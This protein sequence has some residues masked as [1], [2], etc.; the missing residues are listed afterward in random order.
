MSYN[1]YLL[2]DPP[3]LHRPSFTNLFSQLVHLLNR[4]VSVQCAN[5]L[6][7]SRVTLIYQVRYYSEH[8]PYSTAASPTSATARAMTPL[9]ADRAAALAIH[10]SYAS[11]SSSSVKSKPP[12][13]AAALVP[14]VAPPVV[15][16]PLPVQ[17]S[18]VAGLLPVQV[19][20]DLTI[21]F[22]VFTGPGNS[23]QTPTG[24]VLA[25][26]PPEVATQAPAVPT[27]LVPV[28]G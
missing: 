11:P 7:S 26:H 3:F 19:Y 24:R 1:L 14:A 13:R 10:R 23:V 18:L 12:H 28:L 27:L 9:V 15:L 17:E 2:T 5:D 21:I 22:Q 20:V 6:A 4:F 25:K 16:A 8:T